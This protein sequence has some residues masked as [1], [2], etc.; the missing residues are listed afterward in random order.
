MYP[1]SIVKEGDSVTLLCNVNGCDIERI[2]RRKNNIVLESNT[3]SLTIQKITRKKS[4][5]YKCIAYN[6]PFVEFS[7]EKMIDLFCKLSRLSQIYNLH[8]A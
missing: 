7:N 6:D 3:S 2:K 8:N 1:K 4:G 5:V